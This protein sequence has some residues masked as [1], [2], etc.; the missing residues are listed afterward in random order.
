MTVLSTDLTPAEV[1]LATGKTKPASQA[2]ALAK[3]G[4]PFVFLGNA[5]RVARP[6]AQAFE[7]L[8]QTRQT[9]GVDFSRV[10]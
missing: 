6:V 5:V 9:G 4:I 10:R 8:P 3:R 2:A 7:L 1:T